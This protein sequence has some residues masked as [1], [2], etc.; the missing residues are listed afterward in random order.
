MALNQT[1]HR[2]HKP[3]NMVSTAT[4]FVSGPH[5]LRSLELKNS[6]SVMSE[7]HQYQN[8]SQPDAM[9]V[10]VD[11]VLPCEES[12]L[13]QHKFGS[14]VTTERRGSRSFEASH[15]PTEAGQRLERFPSE[16]EVCFGK[17]NFNWTPS[18][19]LRRHSS[20]DI[21]G[22]QYSKESRSQF[23]PY[24]RHFSED[25]FQETQHPLALPDS[26]YTLGIVNGF[27]E[28]PTSTSSARMASLSGGIP[29]DPAVQLWSHRAL[30]S[31]QNNI[32]HNLPESQGS[33]PEYQ[34]SS[35]SHPE[36]ERSL[37]L[38]SYQPQE[39]MLYPAT[40][41][42][43]QCLP[44]SS[45]AV[46]LGTP[47]SYAYQRIAPQTNQDTQQPAYPKPIYSYRHMCLGSNSGNM[48]DN[49]T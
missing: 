44:A 21:N 11:V 20:D 4:G 38:P 5:P 49:G 41:P 27:K 28:S 22:N 7:T 47:S 39:Q 45:Y 9:Q 33:M 34:R 46:A 18:E 29:N 36:Q 10:P 2:N 15:P 43:L 48:H 32:S 26:C 14:K 42:I 3:S 13:Q 25:A 16:Q 24:R 37:R 31:D 40:R 23:H 17:A 12:S 30:C 8:Q 6:F 1:I 19:K 35:L